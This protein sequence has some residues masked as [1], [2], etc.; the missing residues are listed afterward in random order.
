MALLPHYNQHKLRSQQF[1]TDEEWSCADTV[2]S[3]A[4]ICNVTSVKQ[5]QQLKRL[6]DD[7]VLT[8]LADNEQR[9]AQFFGTLTA[10]LYGPGDD[11]LSDAISGFFPDGENRTHFKQSIR[12]FNDVLRPVCFELTTESLAAARQNAATEAGKASVVPGPNVHVEGGEGN[13]RSPIRTEDNTPHQQLKQLI[14]ARFLTPLGDDK[15]RIGA[16]IH[17]LFKVW[18]RHGDLIHHFTRHFPDGE[19]REDILQRI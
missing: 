6:I 19:D 10:A 17:S 2:A 4:I 15:H 9:R 1:A 7:L 5:H 18:R 11:G 16:F 12:A 8:P 13:I 14:C 3:T